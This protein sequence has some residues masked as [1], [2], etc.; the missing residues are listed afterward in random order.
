M[1]RLVHIRRALM[2][3]GAAP[4]QSHRYWRVKVVTTGDEPTGRVEVNE[5][6]FGDISQV[7]FTTTVCT[8]TAADAV[9]IINTQGGTNCKKLTDNDSTDAAMGD[10]LFA[11]A[12]RPE[13]TMDYT[14]AVTPY[15]VRQAKK[16]V[17]SRQVAT[18]TVWYSDNGTDFTQLGGTITLPT[19]V[20]NNSFAAWYQIQ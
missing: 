4:T 5:L 10:L 12:I 2:M 8:C 15:Y 7:S 9:G 3:G 16:D 17:D 6:N 20:T 13:L 19:T 18:C 11:A 1:S 14:S